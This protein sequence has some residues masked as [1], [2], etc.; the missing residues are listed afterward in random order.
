[1]TERCVGSVT[2]LDLVGTITIG[3]DADRLKDKITSLIRQSRTSVIL[4]LA[5]ISYIDSGGLAQLV[6]SYAVLAKTAVSLGGGL[7]VA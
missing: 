6:A 5:G 2:I 4:N 7:E 3:Q 1:M